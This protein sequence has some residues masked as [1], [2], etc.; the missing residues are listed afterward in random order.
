VG[1]SNH[2]GA[3]ALNFRYNIS[4]P[5]RPPKKKAPSSVSKR[6]ASKRVLGIPGEKTKRANGLRRVSARAK[7]IT[8]SAAPVEATTPPSVPAPESRQHKFWKWAAPT[9]ATLLFFSPLGF[10]YYSNWF[11]LEFVASQTDKNFSGVLDLFQKGDVDKINSL[12]SPEAK[13]E[14]EGKLPQL[15]QF[16]QQEGAVL[17]SH[18]IYWTTGNGR[19]KL[20]YYVDFEKGPAMLEMIYLPEGEGNQV[21]KY[22]IQPEDQTFTQFCAFPFNVPVIYYLFMLLAWGLVLLNAHTL[23]R[24]CFMPLKRKWLWILFILIGIGDFT[25]DWQIGGSLNLNF[26]DIVMPVAQISRNPLMSPWEIGFTIPVGMIV[27]L[28]TH[29]KTGEKA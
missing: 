14:A 11:H 17:D 4:M 12:L 24:C 22:S 27:F 19:T 1:A 16:I 18:M 26:L 2:R 25:V 5:S 6:S 28:L 8:L 7:D 10:P 21:E 20:F 23:V 13:A 9:L 3:I 15:I 29:R